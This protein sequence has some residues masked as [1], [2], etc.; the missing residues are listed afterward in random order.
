MIKSFT[1][2]VNSLLR[3]LSKTLLVFAL[4]FFFAQQGSAQTVDVSGLC[5]TSTVNLSVDAGSPLDGKVWYSGNSGAVTVLGF[6]NVQLDIYWSNV[7]NVWYLAF[8]GQP[9]FQNATN[10]TTPPPTSQI[11]WTPVVDNLNCLTGSALV[12]G[13]TGAPLLFTCPTLAATSTTNYSIFSGDNASDIS[14]ST[15]VND[16]NMK[17]VYFT[18]PQATNA[19]RYTG[20]TMIGSSTTP[21]AGAVA[22]NN[23]SFPVN[24]TASPITYYVYAILDVTDPQYTDNTCQPSVAFEVTVDKN[25]TTVT[26]NTF[27]NTGSIT[28]NDGGTGGFMGTAATPYP[29]N[30]FVSGL[31][32]IIQSVTVDLKGMVHDKSRDIDLLLVAPT[33]QQFLMMTGVG[34]G[35]RNGFTDP[36]FTRIPSDLTL[37]DAAV[38]ALPRS[39]VISSGTY[40]PASYETW[41]NTFPAPA[42]PYIQPAPAEPY[43][44]PAPVGTATF[45][46]VFNGLVPNGTW[47]LF[48]TDDTS[49]TIGS[50]ADGWCLNFTLQCPSLSTSPGPAII[51]ESSCSPGCT[52]AGGNIAAP[53]GTCP[54]GSTL[55]YKVGNGPWTNVQPTY[56]QTTAQ[57]IKTRCSCDADPTMVSDSSA[58][59]TV[60]GTCPSATASIGMNNGPICSGNNAV[61][62]VTGTNGSTLTYHTGGGN[63]TLLLN[64]SNQQITVPAVVSNTTLNLVSVATGGSPVCTTL[65]SDMSTVNVDPLPTVE[66]GS[67]RL[68]CAS[69]D[70]I[71]LNGSFGGAATSATWS[72]G[73][74]AFTPNANTLNAV[75]TF[76][77]ADTAA[78]VVKLYLTTNDPAGP[79]V[80]AKDSIIITID[81]ASIVNAGPDQTIC[82]TD[83]IYLSATLSGVADALVW[84][85]NAA[86]GTFIGSDTSPNAKYVLNATGQQ[87]SSIK[88]GVMSSDPGG[89]VCPGGLDTVQIFI[90]P[91]AYVDA[92]VDT[93]ICASTISIKLNGSISGA[94]TTATWTTSG[95][96]TFSP[97]AT[98]LNATYT[99]SLADT[100]AG[101]VTLTLTTNDPAGALCGP[102]VDTRVITIDPASIVNA[103][104]DQTICATDTIYLSAT[105][106]GVADALVWQKNA[107]FGDFIGS[108]TSPNAKYVLNATGQQ[109]SSIKFGV[110][111]SDP[112][113]NV[114]PGGLD[115]VEIFLSDPI[116]ASVSIDQDTIC[117]GAEFTLT[118]NESTLPQG[119]EFT[120]VI[121]YTDEN[122][123]GSKTLSNVINGGQTN[124]EEG[125]DFDGILT[126]TQII[127]TPETVDFCADT[128]D[129]FKV[130]VVV[131]EA[132]ISDPCVCVNN[133]EIGQNGSNSN[134]G[135]FSD[136]V[137]I[138]GPINQTW[139]VASVTGYYENAAGTDSVDVG[140]VFTQVSPGI[141]ELAGYHID[142]IG[143][144][145]TVSN[146]RGLTLQTGNKCFYPDPVFTGL[147][148]LVAPSAAPFQVTGT[149]A[150]N[151]TGTG[152]FILDGV[153]QAG[154]SAAPTVV[155]I[156]PGTLSPGSHTLVYQFDA[157][158]A[159]SN[160]LSDP[161]CV[162]QVRQRFQVANCGCQDV[163]VSLDANCQFVLTGNLVSDVNCNGGTV[164]VMDNN[165]SNGGLIDCAGVWTYGLF[166]AFGNIICWG[167][168]TAEDK[169][170]PALICAPRDFTLD[171]Y[172]VNYVLNNK[173]TIGDVGTFSSPRPAATS[174]QTFL[175]AE[176]ISTLPAGPC[177]LPS[178]MLVSDNIKN[179][180]YAYFKDNC[181][182]C[183][184]RVT[185]K[186]SDKVV[187]YSCTDMAT[188]GGIYAKISREWV[189][190]D[191]NGM[192]SDYTQTIYFTRPAIDLTAG[193]NDRGL[194]FRGAGTTGAAATVP[195]PNY[196]WVVEYGSCT[197]DKGLIK[198][199]D[200]TPTFCSYFNN[201]SPE[202]K[203]C[204]FIGDIECNYSVQIK[205]TEFPICGGKGVKI[206]RELYVFDWCEGGIVDTFHILI[207]IGDFT[208]PKLEYA[209]HAPFVIS[210]GPMDC[211][212]AFPVTV[213]GIKSAFGVSIVDNCAVANATVI[214][215]TKDRYVKGILVAQNTWDQVDY[216]IMNGMMIGVPVGTHRMIID[217]F[218]GCYNAKRD[219]FDFE[220]ADKIA[221]VMK[222]DDELNISLSNGNGYT[223]GY[224]QASADDIDE[225]SWDNCKMAFIAVRRNV[226]TGCEASFIAKGYDTNNNGKLD[227]AV[228]TDLN[229]DGDYNDTINGVAEVLKDG[230][231]GFDRNGDGDFKDFGE[232]FIL[233]GGKLMTPLQDKVEFFC[234]DLSALVTIELWGEDTSGNR[235]FCW[236]ELVIEDKVAPTCVAPWNVTVDCDEKCLEKIEDKTASARCFGDVTI[237]SGNDCAGMDTVYTVDK[238][239]KCGYGTITRKWALTKKTVKGP[240][241]IN[242]SQTITVR[243][244]HEYN[245]CFP[246]DASSD[247]KTPIVD[248]IITDEL[249]CDILTVNVTDKR[250]DASGDECYKIFRTYSVI[251]WCTYDDRCGDPL[252]QTNVHVID[253]GVF[254]NY[255]KDP[256]YLLVRDNEG[257]VR[258]G[259]EEFWAS[260]DLIVS[261]STDIRDYPIY[262]TVAGEY[263]HSFIYTQIIKVYDDTRPVVTGDPAKFC[264]REGADCLADL[265]MV[266]TGK[267]NCSNEVTLETQSLMIAPGRTLKASEMI[268]FNTTKWSTKALGNG[269]FEINVKDLPQGQHDLIVVVRDECGNLSVPTRIPFTVEDCKGPSPICINGL[270]VDLM[271][272]GAGGGMMT[273]WASDFVA[274]KVF[275]C[276]GQGPETHKDNSNL[277]LVTK[278]SVNRVK[279]P[280]VP[281]QTSIS[282]TCADLELGF[283]LVELHAW[284]E[285]GNHDFCVTFIEVQDNRKV[286][287]G[288]STNTANIAGTIATEGSAKLQ[289]ASI[290]L[291]G[292]ASQTATTSAN[293]GYSFVNLSKG[294]DFTVTPQL[295]KNHLNGVSTFDLVLIQKHILGI[296]ALNS[297]YKL[298][299]ADVNNSKSISTL[300]MIQLRKLILNIDATFQNN[301]SWR[302][303]DAAYVFAEP[304]NPWSANFPE[305][306]SVNNL[307]N[308]VTANFVAIKVGDV[309]ASASVSSATSAEVRSNGAFKLNT[310]EQ[311]LKA[312]NEYRVA[313]TGADLPNIQGY[314]FALNLDQSKVELVD[315]EYG[316]AK[317]ENFGIFKNEGLITTSWNQEGLAT[318]TA[319]AGTLFT[320]VLRAKAEAKLSSALSLNRSVSPEAYNQ[321][322][323]NLGI[324]LNYGLEAIADGYELLQ[325]TPNPFNG[326]TQIGFKLPKAT[327]ATLSVSDSKGALIYKVEGNYAK[328]NNQVTLKKEQLGASG[329]LYY[330]LETTEFI[331]TKKMVILE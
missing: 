309:N 90:S 93:T 199:E 177:S 120:V 49:G 79:C 121:K 83:T 130:E 110:M 41:A 52:L 167:K 50:I 202:N 176:G 198:K 317:A 294:G 308:N 124:F 51:T 32:G 328:G 55:Q 4:A 203:R 117:V 70:T 189:A 134:T 81:P 265:K 108:D 298:I 77:A 238:S 274:S 201:A 224:A 257:G 119:S 243:A 250:Y 312:G 190:T 155:T 89:N 136:K 183:G 227:A 297:P 16:L 263:I 234:C 193:A 105:L 313:F 138:E 281:T 160:N 1:P 132:M 106:S 69:Q 6:T 76:T 271:P 56:N 135:T 208:P 210:T 169:T 44:Q 218:D 5:I 95:T 75:Y 101:T 182:G 40:R 17:L 122:G 319:K 321:H 260:K 247:C 12:I 142:A 30:I 58:V 329:V 288:S 225:G 150:N 291:S 15:T 125:I 318:A 137:T 73:T 283:I 244:V 39:S 174:S 290:T 116:D 228:G 128:L 307:T 206:D 166:D 245:I 34:D 133:A 45:A 327:K 323:E 29:S 148:A 268:M 295:D 314:Q 38:S 280:V 140:D 127:V 213:A 65:L 20:G 299:A 68:I 84:Q 231:D 42:S 286:C 267:D 207:K 118:F 59:T 179:L 18:S 164:R 97:N 239:L 54:T 126:V 235:N 141:Y 157:D 111:S 145:I 60:P 107:A 152:T 275:D 233:K 196:D 80:L 22:F 26:G 149:V 94:A 123:A 43:S 277:K 19:L 103:G 91:A 205:D 279:E 262:C 232:T 27:C 322:N 285:A 289:G 316:V 62:T 237:T 88:F 292:A 85:K 47:Q 168:V 223:T 154:A 246:K 282:V 306:V 215:K 129:G 67:D 36:N 304:G 229:S 310:Q 296:Q 109:L 163:T 188:N 331:A 53:G 192:R 161:G 57:T 214:V 185:L 35:I 320:L 99:P 200:V 7:D 131:C 195:A 24:N 63:Q 293:G 266:I 276:N 186:W 194:R 249:S 256:I 147:P 2:K 66:A 156:N 98:T 204:L 115:T 86:F 8:D 3:A 25:M 301:T 87:L 259:E 71:R 146:G 255:G 11:T 252:L 222:C 221:P 302:F 226:P 64:G 261:P 324:A 248:T 216:A 278:Y 162:Q 33:G 251:N 300:D 311:S 220:V 74:G 184:C 240:I 10:S 170:A 253:R 269:Q 165:P 315:I 144:T 181:F 236:D 273:V 173:L 104:P 61:F 219:S 9:Y 180:G 209:H 211:T 326:E 96:G 21:V 272:D 270:S 230:A 23:L 242:C 241:T 92:G 212:A 171:C 100:A 37:S 305:V 158:T 217:A 102:A 112:G 178:S 254:D 139:T 258:D 72:G 31:S 14:V 48:A 114:C 113:G 187:F 197:A 325:N 143:Y 303:V 175:N 13:G 153:P 82:A 191:C 78:N 159:S 264:I 151:A 28:L 330:T 284:D 172:D 287:P 46:N